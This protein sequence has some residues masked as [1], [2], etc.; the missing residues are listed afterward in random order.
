MGPVQHAGLPSLSRPPLCVPR[1][2]VGPTSHSLRGPERGQTIHDPGGP[3]PHALHGRPIHP[4]RPTLRP[5]DPRAMAPGQMRHLVPQSSDLP[6]T[7]YCSRIRPLPWS[8]RDG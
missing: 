3:T 8:L 4:W 2:S 6:S 1:P 7:G 5:E